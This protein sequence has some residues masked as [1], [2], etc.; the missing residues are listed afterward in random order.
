MA[1]LLDND[2]VHKL[3]QLD[4][5]PEAKALLGGEFGV[6]KILDT[7][8]FKFCPRDPSKR[9][10]A[11]KKHGVIVISRIEQFIANDIIEVSDV[12]KDDA[13]LN[14]VAINPE[15]LDVGEM[16]LL[17]AL[18]DSS[19][20][21]LF[22]GDKRFMKALTNVS[23]LEG[24][25]QQVN[26]CFICFEQVIYFLIQKL[27]FE[28]VKTKF[29]QALED[30]IAVDSTLKFC[31]EGRHLAVQ[32]Q[33]VDNLRYHIGVLRKETGQLLAVSEKWLPT[34]RI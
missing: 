34:N 8:K 14:A 13:L 10:K 33:V 5:L 18:C 6:L 17:Q 7:L 30:G 20:E 21:L 25:L 16:Q 9:S 19:N 26:G 24:M 28:H 15:G 31:F 27:G 32:S 12:V 22:T 4:L 1:L 11:E 2:I 23:L 29:V 3:A